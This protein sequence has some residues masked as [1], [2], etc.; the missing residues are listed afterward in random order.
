MKYILLK[1]KVNFVQYTTKNYTNTQYLYF[2]TYT[3]QFGVKKSD[4]QTDIDKYKVTAHIISKKKNI[5]PKSVITSRCY[6]QNIDILTYL[7]LNTESV[8]N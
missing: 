8:K 1:N 6:Q 5:S 2:I 7:Y 4:W 3:Y